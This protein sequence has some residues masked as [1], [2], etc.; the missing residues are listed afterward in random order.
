MTVP[1]FSRLFEG[2]TLYW[3][4]L[5]YPIAFTDDNLVS[6]KYQPSVDPLLLLMI[7]I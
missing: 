5:M 7:Q 3:A 1:V 4:P 2:L 6:L